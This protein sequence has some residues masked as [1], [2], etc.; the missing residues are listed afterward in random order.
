MLREPQACPRQE[1]LQLFRHEGIRLLSRVC[2]VKILV[3]TG[4]SVRPDAA[5]LIKELKALGVRTVMVTGDAPATAQIVARQVG[6]DGA[7]CPQGQI[8][9]SVSP[10]SFAV[11]AGVMPEAKFH[12]VQAFQK[13]GH[14]VG[15]CG[16]GA[17]DAPA[18]RQA[19]MGIAVSTATDVAKSAAG[20]V[21]T[22]PGLEGVVAAV[23][24]GRTTF[25]R[26]L[27]YT[28][29]SVTKK[30][31]QVLF[32]AVGL[33]IT[34]QAILTPML[35]VLIMITGDF[36]G[37]SLTTDNVRPSPTPSVWRVGD[38]TLA[39]IFMGLSELVLCV[40]ALVV[41]KYHLGF[42]I[43]TLR[44]LAFVVIVFGNQATTY[45]NRARQHLW[46]IAP[47]RWL[48]LSSVVDLTIAATM[49]NRGLAMAPLSLV[50]IGATLAGAVI[51]AF[52]VD[53]VKIPVF[54]HLKIE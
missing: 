23:K 37:M 43:D 36:L 2:T 22:K 30:I 45:T 15:M 10:E 24:E 12:L 44:T 48:V 41:G 5:D 32:L 38:L 47:S 28:V 9:E 7:I 50:V 8:P 26:I 6:I 53:F 17:N 34:G 27:T 52:L 35:M 11:F 16:D 46:S 1:A 20:I 21:L 39:G 42:G 31:V 51:F 13:S 25:Q 40:A 4:E 49:A 18:L 33:L 14:T 3:D 19:Q 29:N 54:K